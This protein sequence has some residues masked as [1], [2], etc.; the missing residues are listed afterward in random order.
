MEKTWPLNKAKT[1]CWYVIPISRDGSEPI[2][3]T[4]RSVKEHE[5]VAEGENP[6]KA[7]LLM[8]EE[9]VRGTSDV[10]DAAGLHIQVKSSFALRG[11]NKV[12]QNSRASLSR[13]L[14]L[15]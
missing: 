4:D 1:Q 6:Q 3:D 7:S 12:W 14:P 2:L 11:Q 10:A 9:K 5:L 13:G 8:A 15:Q